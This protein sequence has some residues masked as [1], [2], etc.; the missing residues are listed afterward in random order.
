MVTPVCTID[1]NGISAPDFP[2]VLAYFQNAYR[3]IYGQDVYLGNDSQDGQFIALLAQ[4]LHDANSMTVSVYNAYSPA[5]AQGAGLASVVKTNGITKKV[6]TNSL[7]DLLL[8]GVAFT[9]ILNGVVTDQDSNRWLL[10]PLVQ[11]PVTGQITVTATAEDAGAIQAQANTVT[12]ISTPTKGWQT[13]T[14]PAAA[15]PGAPVETDPQLKARQTISTAL[16]SLTVFDGILGAIAAIPGVARLRGYENDG[17]IPDSN[18]I[19]GHCLSMVVDGGDAAAIAAAIAL[20][21][22]IAGTYGTTTEVIVNAQG[23]ARSINFF[24][25]TE[26]PI[27]YFMLVKPLAGFS[28]NTIT[29]I[30]QMLSDWT[31][32]LGIG[33]SVPL[34]DAYLPARLFGGAGAN[35]FKIVPDSLVASRDG[36]TFPAQDVVIAFNEAPACDPTYINVSLEI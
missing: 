2:T 6:P 32:G 9:Q 12:T 33:N 11:I 20:K 7:V 16:P 19:P 27:Y 26:V 23:V 15:T 22:S 1:A 13:V 35:T 36:Q 5:T 30:K 31:N 29:T 28:A 24:R 21:K 14:N 34:M 10:P 18:G 17:N 4:A 3:G 8:V 25:P